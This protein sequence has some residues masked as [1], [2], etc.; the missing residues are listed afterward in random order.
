MP[1]QAIPTRN[2]TLFTTD[3]EDTE[4]TVDS[5]TTKSSD[6]WTENR[7]GYRSASS[8][9][10]STGAAARQNRPMAKLI[11]PKS[12]YGFRVTLMP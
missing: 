5:G 2:S 1:I 11:A 12:S 10:R 8:Q 9:V 4:S 7:P 3:L 6:P